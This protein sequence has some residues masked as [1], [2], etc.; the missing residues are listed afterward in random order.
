M[1][2][3]HCMKPLAGTL[4]V[5]AAVAS[6]LA[7][8]GALPVVS[9]GSVV[10]SQ[11]ASGETV[12]VGYTL[13][14]APGVVTID[15]QTNAGENVW[16]SIG[17]ARQRHW[18][19]ACN[20]LLPPGD[21]T[22]TWSVDADFPGF[23]FGEGEA[24]AVVT[25]WATNAPPDY[26]VVDLSVPTNTYFYADAEFL[27][28]GV[29]DVK[30]KTEKLLLR[31][32]PAANVTWNKGSPLSEKGR[33]V[34]Y[35]GI[36]SVMLSK[37]FY[38]GVFEVTQGQY[39]RCY[40]YGTGAY[41]AKFASEPDAA[42]RPVECV[43][44]TTVRGSWTYGATEAPDSGSAI[45]RLRRH[46]GIMFD[47]PF[48]A[49]WEFA[50]RAG[51]QNAFYNGGDLTDALQTSDEKL[52][53]IAWYTGNWDDDPALAGLENRTHVVGL[54]QSNGFGLYD[55][56]GNVQELVLDWRTPTFTPVAE[57][58]TDPMGPEERTTDQGEMYD[59][60][61]WCG[62]AYNKRPSGCRV[63]SR[64]AWV[65]NAVDEIGFRVTAPAE[66]V[67]FNEEVE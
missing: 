4:G 1:R 3:R 26:M 25:A 51:C 59:G 44:A 19:G 17:G 18:A 60:Y 20:K 13:T 23:D 16:V 29:Q 39:A 5:L 38:I 36:Q 58:V 10:A 9:P 15:I 7:V 21:Y 67:L 45:G 55:M 35:E 65:L 32:I 41:P 63:S 12:T 66:A 34:G 40:R 33:N 46:S 30:Y 56:L 24:R 57:T 2:K 62:G 61:C 27:P 37:D 22:A 43:N 11:P 50:C 54:K 52:D 14:T 48:E 28:G 53:E 31:K 47:L 8:Q 64:Y 6:P 42:L 49:Q